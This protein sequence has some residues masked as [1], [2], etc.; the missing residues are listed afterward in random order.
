MRQQKGEGS[1]MKNK[2][3]LGIGSLTLVVT[4]SYYYNSHLNKAPAPIVSGAEMQMEHRDLASVSKKENLQLSK[5]LVSSLA[6]NENK[7][8]SQ[9]AKKPTE[10]DKFVLEDLQG[11]YFVEF[12][13]GKV[14]SFHFDEQ[15][16]S[17]PLNV[18]KVKEFLFSHKNIWAISFD[19]VQE[20]KLT[21]P[22]VDSKAT[23]ENKNLVQS[24]QSKVYEL[25]D[26]HQKVVGKVTFQ[27]DEK[28]LWKSLEFVE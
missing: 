16:N 23:N 8:P 25:L 17:Q 28:G 5:N 6:Q 1:F 10:L 11:R 12:S 19:Q 21:P 20:L 14:K 4:L 9:V 15:A 26:T 24:G 27:M 13:K 22:G 18:P 2:L 3:W 7:L